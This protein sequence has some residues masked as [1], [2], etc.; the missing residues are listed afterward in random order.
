MEPVIWISLVAIALALIAILAVTHKKRREIVINKTMFAVGLM[1][2]LVAALMEFCQ[3]RCFLR[4][5]LELWPAVLGVIGI[6]LIIVSNFCT[7]KGKK[8]RG[9]QPKSTGKNKE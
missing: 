9:M 2:A 4:T 3:E 5:D 6:S 1:I 7:S 8:R